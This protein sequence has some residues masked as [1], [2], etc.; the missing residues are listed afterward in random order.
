MLQ[1]TLENPQ[2]NQ[3]N[4]LDVTITINGYF[5]TTNWYRK[6]TWSGKYF[7]FLSYTPKKYKISVINSPTDR[8]VLLSDK[9]DQEL[10]RHILYK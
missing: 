8:N 1:F 2:N 9:E 7:N 3:I 4:F 10:I 6:P 5:C